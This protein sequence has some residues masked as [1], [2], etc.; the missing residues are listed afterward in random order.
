MPEL[1]KPTPNI[2]Y[3]MKSPIYFITSLLLV[4]S[5]NTAY[6]QNDTRHTTSQVIQRMSEALEVYDPCHYKAQ[7]R[8]KEMGGDT[9][10]IRKFSISYKS[11]PANPLYG[12]DWEIM[13]VVDSGYAYTWM[14]LPKGVYV[15]FEGSK[16]IGQLALPRQIDLGSY[17]EYIRSSFVLRE[18][19]LPFTEVSPK[20][21]VL[22]DAGKDY[23]LSLQ[24]NDMATRQLTISKDT[25][26]PVQSISTINGDGF[27]YVQITE[28]NFYFDEPLT[29]LPDTAFSVDH[30]LSIGYTLVHN[31]EP[32]SSALAETDTVSAE[33]AE[34]L[35]HYPFVTE[36]GDT[37]FL[38]TYKAGY[39][40]LDFWF[41]SCMPCL[42]ALPL[43]NQMAEVHAKDDLLVIGIN[44]FDKGIRS[45]VAAKLRAKN[46]TIPLLFG[47]R[48]LVRALGITAFPTYLLITPERKLEFIA[49]GAEEVKVKLDLIFGK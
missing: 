34:L 20:E 47:D 9:F 12:Y 11:N 49:G 31:E 6:S 36:A 41:S 15:I 14:V 43:V 42:Q 35:L 33:G 16:G 27:D 32:E 10:E 30:Y 29:T 39:I 44:C 19:V 48:D 38:H 22:S 18:V 13:E 5:I 24:M 23:T 37:T 26:L 2:F 3:L 17:P 7:M 4:S 1:K 46:I 21:I 45:N 25:Y 8:F 40:L 28:I